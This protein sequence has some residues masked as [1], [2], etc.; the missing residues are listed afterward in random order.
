MRRKHNTYHFQKVSCFVT[1]SKFRIYGSPLGVQYEILNISSVRVFWDR[2][3]GV[4]KYK[5]TVLCVQTGNTTEKTKLRE[6][7]VLTD[8]R[9]GDYLVK[10][11][12]VQNIA[13]GKYKLCSKSKL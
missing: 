4:D 12:A 3:P 5:V 13:G 8:L 7:C 2:V 1:L 11:A 9:Q 10:V 6:S